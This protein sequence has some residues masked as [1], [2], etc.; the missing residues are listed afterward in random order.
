MAL[1]Q[2]V[3]DLARATPWAHGLVLAYA[4]YGL[5]LFALLLLVGWW[6]A[7]RCGPQSMAAAL[8]AGGATLL[9][10][11]LNQPLVAAFAEARPYTTHPGILVLA[12][13]SADLSF[14]S[15]HA[16]MAGAVAA[17]L[18]LVSRRLGATAT[19]AALLMAFARVYIGAHY[20]RDVL[21]GL[22][23]GAAVSLGGWALL[24]RPLTV[25]VARSQRT[26]LSPLLRT[27][28]TSG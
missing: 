8:W 24:R 3:N 27:S 2:T 10:V 11:A 7:R 13:R 17:G 18:C 6:T 14:P 16:V 12:H 22:A 4:S 19:I 21:A 25:L 23:L 9:A 1:F 28:A 5:A 26:P 20:P 15:D